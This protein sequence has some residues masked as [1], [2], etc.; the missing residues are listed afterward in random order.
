MLKLPVATLV[1][2]SVIQLAMVIYPLL[3]SPTEFQ[4]RF[5]KRKGSQSG[6][7]HGVEK[8]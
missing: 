4:P 8:L 2:Y 3:S 1:T 6:R 7:Q 5:R